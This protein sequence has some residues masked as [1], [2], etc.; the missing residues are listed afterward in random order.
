MRL[1]SALQSR[2]CKGLI[3]SLQKFAEKVAQK[4]GT[5]VDMQSGKQV[6]T[7]ALEKNNFNTTQS[8]KK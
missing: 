8:R 6:N 3:M 1:S 7:Q 5:Q 4:L 2:T